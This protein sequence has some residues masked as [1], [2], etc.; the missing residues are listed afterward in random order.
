MEGGDDDGIDGDGDGDEDDVLVLTVVMVMA[1][2]E[3]ERAND[4]AE[5]NCEDSHDCL[6]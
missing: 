1:T 2:V 6:R 4:H 3:M 5:G